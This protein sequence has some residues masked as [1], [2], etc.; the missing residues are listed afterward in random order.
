MHVKLGWVVGRLNNGQD[1][2]VWG[3][4]VGVDAYPWSL[5][6]VTL[7]WGLSRGVCVLSLEGFPLPTRNN[8]SIVDR[9]IKGIHVHR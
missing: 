2:S 1:G 5:V 8:S 6:C 7:T 3:R 9:G 4:V